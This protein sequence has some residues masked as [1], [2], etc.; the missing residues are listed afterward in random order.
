VQ[1]C[2]R[3]P[4]LGSCYTSLEFFQPAHYYFVFTTWQSINK[5]IDKF[6]AVPQPSLC[7]EQWRWQIGIHYSATSAEETR[8]RACC[9]LAGDTWHRQRSGQSFF[10]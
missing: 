6:V 8:A 3:P 10:K 7:L 1:V 5:L 2:P 4:A 9:Q